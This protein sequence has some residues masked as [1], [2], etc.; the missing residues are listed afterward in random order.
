MA[1]KAKAKKE[2]KIIKTV[3]LVTMGCDKNTVDSERIIGGLVANGFKMTDDHSEAD[4]V[5]INTCGFIKAAKE[6]SVNAI[7][8]AGELKQDGKMQKLIITG[9]LTQRYGKELK[10][11][12]KFV[13]HFFG[14]NSEQ[15]ILNALTTGNKTHL[16]GERELLTP[17]HYAFLKISE[18]CTHSCSFCSIPKIRGK[19]I[20]RLEEE[21]LA[22]VAMLRDRGVKELNII[23]QDTTF[24]GKDIDGKS[25]LADLLGKIS[26]E[27]I[28][29][30]RIRLLYTYPTGFPKEVLKVIAERK[31]ICNYIDVPLQHIVSTILQSMKRGIDSKKIKELIAEIRETI[32]GVAIRTS[33]I[34]GYPG[35]TDDH[36][37]TL[38]NFVKETK[39]DRVGVFTYSQEDGTPAFNLGDPIPEYIKIERSNIIMEAQQEITLEK[40]K[41]L[42]GTDIEV[43]VDRIDDKGLIIGRTE[44]DAPGVDN[45]VILDPKKSIKP[46][47]FVIATITDAQPY[48][49]IGK[50]KKKR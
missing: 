17:P 37:D 20:S 13:D 38:L 39:L 46:G 34:T 1:K 35:E 29:D 7:V 9:C 41:A 16:I 22:E 25:L 27:F 28:D 21:I 30:G 15:K 47:D 6:E 44:Y 10:K 23:A 31:N 26:D 40:N 36:F 5:I 19:H 48:D 45:G 50:V 49:L 12:I 4:A 42:I 3:A 2:V 18:G 43:I 11:Q 24:Y 33:F 8:E 32:P 14:T